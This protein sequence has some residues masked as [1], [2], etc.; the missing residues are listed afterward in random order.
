[1]PPLTVKPM[2]AVVALYSGENQELAEAIVESLSR[3]IF[4]GGP[5]A[6]AGLAQQILARISYRALK[7]TTRRCK[8]KGDMRKSG[9]FSNPILE[10]SRHPY[11][12]AMMNSSCD[13]TEALVEGGDPMNGPYMMI[14]PEILKN[15]G[16]WDRMFLH[17]VQG[18][19]VQLRF[20]WETQATYQEA[21]TRLEKG[22]TVR[23]KAVA[24]GTG[25]S[26]VLAYDRLI[27]DGCDP[28]RLT[29]R[30]TDRDKANAEKTGRLLAKLGS[31]RSRVTATETAGGISVGTEDLFADEPAPGVARAEKYDVV[32]AVG[33]LE[34]FQG[35]TS[36][37]T[38]QSHGLPEV[39]DTTTAHHLAEK[40]DQMTADTGALIVNTYRPHASIRIMELFGRRFDYR[41][42]ANLSELLATAHFRN[43]RLIGS[44]NIYDLKVYEKARAG[45][46]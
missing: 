9:T 3:A 29:V 26:M 5:V 1:M 34:Y 40:L 28:A 14:S 21:K 46:D 7:W 11:A 23:M 37:S 41:H 15:G 13:E 42:I 35:C 27:K 24:A 33:I 25:L 18:R 20:I 19:D 8:A 45:R 36:G 10:R 12:W 31:T 16:F 44:G 39:V 22:E 2:D 38:E 17:S 30:I 4:A 43:P 6:P 32:T